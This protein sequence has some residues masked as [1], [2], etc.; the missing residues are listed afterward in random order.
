MPPLKLTEFNRAGIA[1]EVKTSGTDASCKM[2]FVVTPGD[3]TTS[4]AFLRVKRSPEVR[5]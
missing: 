1:G 4:R 5:F 3:S 2:T